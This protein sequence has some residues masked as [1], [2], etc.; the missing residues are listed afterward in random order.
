MFGALDLSAAEL[1]ACCA[2][3]VGGAV[4]QGAIGFGYAFVVV[5]ALLLVAPA[6]VPA[7]AL[8]V[9]LPMVLVLAVADR[10]WLDRAGF[11]RLTLGRVPGTVAGAWVLTLVGAD[12]LTALAG[13]L[14]LTAAAASVARGARRASPRLEVV[15]GFASGLA[16]TVGALGG[17]YLGLAYADRPGPVLR[18]TV[19]AAFAVGVLLSLVA[20]AIAGELARPAV[21]LGIALIPATFAGLGLG[22]RLR[23]RLDAGRLRPAVLAFAGTAGL[24]TLLRAAL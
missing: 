8:V 7:A 18:A 21:V 14:L 10:R 9:A 11:A 2:A 24:V 23:G 4:V 1:A 13:G 15:A 17:P 5:P 12:V 16:G 3:A 6:A 20:I 22:R 19:S